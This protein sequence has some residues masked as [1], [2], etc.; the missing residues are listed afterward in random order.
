[1]QAMKHIRD[2]KRYKSDMRFEDYI[3]FVEDGTLKVIKDWSDSPDEALLSKE[4]M[5]IIERAVNEL[6]MHYRIV[7]HLRDV[8]GLSNV[9]VVKILGLSLSGAKSR[10]HRARLFLRNKLSDY[11]YEYGK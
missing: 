10:V 11:F 8:E 1:M 9:E 3:S 7:F 5:E 2:E 6:P 4:V